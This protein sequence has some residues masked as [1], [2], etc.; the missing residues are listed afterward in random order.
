M[1][2]TLINF[3][4]ALKRFR[5]DNNVKQC[6]VAVAIGVSRTFYN[7]V[8]NGEKELPPARFHKLLE[9]TKEMGYDSSAVE[10]F[11]VGRKLYSLYNGNNPDNIDLAV[12]IVTT[13]LSTDDYIQVRAILEKHRNGR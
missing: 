13:N 7:L 4:K 9:W 6:E 8:E 3:G 10:Q 1:E 11:Y 2:T 5:I 12:N